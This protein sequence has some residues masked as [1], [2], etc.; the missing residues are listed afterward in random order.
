MLAATYRAAIL[1]RSAC[2][3]TILVTVTPPPV[4]V[5][6][7]TDLDVFYTTSTVTRYALSPSPA[8]TPSP[9]A[10]AVDGAAATSV[11]VAA[12]VPA[13]SSLP[14]CSN[15]TTVTATAPV[16]TTT[17]TTTYTFSHASRSTTTLPACEPTANYNL[18]S[19]TLD[20][21][22]VGAVGQPHSVSYPDHDIAAC[23]NECFASSSLS[24]AG[25]LSW[26]WNGT[27]SCSL[28][29]VDGGCPSV[30]DGDAIE[31]IEYPNN[32]KPGVGVGSCDVVVL[33][34]VDG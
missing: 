32:E 4:T 22:Y 23:C 20:I 2:S 19:G 24:G 3:D 30:G 34:F 27:G 7:Y 12:A 15:A 28:D 17:V 13:D 29:V 26:N 14:I 8:L 18:F 33:Y 31:V 9:S 10:S 25:C 21:N 16:P 5:S 11:P 1:K 6:T